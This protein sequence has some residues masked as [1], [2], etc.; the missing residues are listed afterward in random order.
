MRHAFVVSRSRGRAAG[1]ATARVRGL[2]LVAAGC[3]LAGCAA[4]VTGGLP[5]A[6]GHT[7]GP[8][9]ATRL[10]AYVPSWLRSSCA[11]TGT[12]GHLPAAVSGY[13]DSLSCV[14]RADMPAEVDY[15][16]YASTRGT[17]AAYDSAVRSVRVGAALR[18][19]GCATGDDESGTWSAAGPGAGSIACVANAASKVELIW[20]DPNT[21]IIAVAGSEHLILGS[22]YAFWRSN[23]ASIDRS[24]RH[25]R[26]S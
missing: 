5:A 25:A 23:G 8:S 22:L 24:A 15:Y 1:A 4:T 12:R 3:A 7:A 9:A 6:G 17:R 10:F 21:D 16:R 14:L 11:E 13:A 18:P 19:G 20:D 26:S 2:S